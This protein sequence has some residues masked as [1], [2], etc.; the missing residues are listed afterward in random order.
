[1]RAWLRSIVLVL[2]GVVGFVV[3]AT[4]ATLTIVP[5]LPYYES[6]GY[7]ADYGREFTLNIYGDSEGASAYGIFGQLVYGGYDFNPGTRTQ[8][9]LVGAY[10]NWITGI[11][12]Y[13]DGPD[14]YS[15]AFSQ[16]AVGHYPAADTA[17]NLPGLLA[18]VTLIPH[19]SSG[20]FLDIDW[21]T[22]NPNPARRLDFFG[23]TSA[24]GV[25]IFCCTSDIPE[26]STWLLVTFGLL[27]FGL[28]GLGGWPRAR[29]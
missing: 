1:M 20:P 7:V 24:P 16:V 26:P 19:P 15:V 27:G 11:L 23:L 21:D 6:Y 8:T 5:D 28:L 2:I 13:S 10:G 29:E 12:E 14:A 18:K 25:R 4:A 3:T 9:R 17:T 22:T